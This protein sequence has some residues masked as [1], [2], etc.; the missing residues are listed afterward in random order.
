MGMLVK[1]AIDSVHQVRGERHGYITHC[2]QKPWLKVSYI[3]IDISRLAVTTCLTYRIDRP[4]KSSGQAVPMAEPGGHK[5]PGRKPQ[6]RAWEGSLG[7]AEKTPASEKSGGK[8][9]L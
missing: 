2:A 3:K 9:V 7:H 1:G 5:L 6:G 8:G 4:F